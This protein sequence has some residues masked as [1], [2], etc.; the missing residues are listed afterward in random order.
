M[1]P[2]STPN[3]LIKINISSADIRT[4]RV[5]VYWCKYVAFSLSEFK[6][7]AHSFLDIVSYGVHCELE[8][9]IYYD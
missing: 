8:F 3:G 5:V 9:Y 2:K 6:Q 1:S 4:I 7:T